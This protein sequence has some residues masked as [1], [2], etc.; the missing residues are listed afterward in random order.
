MRTQAACLRH[1]REPL[2]GSREGTG[3]RNR[4]PF[5]WPRLRWAGRVYLLRRQRE[6]ALSTREE[7]SQERERLP[8]LVHSCCA[9]LLERR[10]W[11]DKGDQLITCLS[12]KRDA[13]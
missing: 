7:K 4:E 12:G 10:C 5:V 8:S 2:L 3:G 13:G 9:S 1:H 11:Q 6:Q